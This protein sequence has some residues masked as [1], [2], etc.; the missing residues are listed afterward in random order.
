MDD[1]YGFITTAAIVG[2]LVSIVVLLSRAKKAAAPADPLR[3]RAG[4]AAAKKRQ[5][6]LFVTT[7]PELQPHLH[8]EK[9]LQFVNGWRARTARPD[10]VVWN[11]PPGLGVPRVRLQ[12][13][14]DKGQRVELL[15][16]ADA[17]VGSFLIQQHAEGAAL[18]LDP[19]KLTVN[20]RDAA[21]RYWHPQREFKW[22]R[23]KGWRVINALSDRGIES[24]NDGISFSSSSSSSSSTATTVAAAAAG[25]AVVTGAG[26]A[27]DGGG[28]SQ[29]WDAG[30]GSES[31][32]SY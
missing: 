5:E 4:G 18:R 16:A 31:R 30:S 12:P 2:V 26:G 20:V 7:F 11:N 8:P 22:S 28:S 3:L 25:A 14:T 24:S 1:L 32:T 19:G 17:L 21:V 10:P 15:D 27:F 29:S 9:V 23:A 13:A 6:A